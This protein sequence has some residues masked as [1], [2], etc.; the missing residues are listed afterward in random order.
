MKIV[1]DTNVLVSAIVFGGK[2]KELL[3]RSIETGTIIYTSAFIENEL[4]R[5]LKLKFSFSQEQTSEA[6]RFIAETF[7]KIEPEDV[8]EIIKRD[9]SDNNILAL[10]TAVGADYIISGD[11]D[12]LDLGAY[13]SIPI[14]TSHQFLDSRQ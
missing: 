10:A 7:V 11:N 3:I 14:L 6:G 1:L 8:P 5:V 4:Q 12:L 13:G 2:P 9:I